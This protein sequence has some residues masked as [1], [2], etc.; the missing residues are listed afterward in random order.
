MHPPSMPRPRRPRRPRARLALVALAACAA[1]AVAIGARPDA[2]QA[3]A[4]LERE[5]AV[6]RGMPSQE[7]QVNC[8]RDAYAAHAELRRGRST[9]ADPAQLAANALKRCDPLPE[10]DRRDCVARMQGE[11]TTRGS[12]AEGGIYRELVT[13]VPEPTGSSSTAASK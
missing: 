6:C 10:A 7:A 4:V 9:A 8:R 1:S 3:R 11:G 13:R 5:L 12:V 2:A